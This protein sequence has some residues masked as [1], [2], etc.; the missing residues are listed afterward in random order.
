MHQQ[1]VD[2]EA[3]ASVVHI[4]VLA[5]EVLAKVLL[6]VEV[7]LIAV[8]QVDQVTAGLVVQVQQDVHLFLYQFQYHFFTTVTTEVMDMVVFL[9]S[10][11]YFS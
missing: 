4:A 8:A 5:V 10:K 2:L 11:S 1:E 6:Q 3:E 7:G 9:Y